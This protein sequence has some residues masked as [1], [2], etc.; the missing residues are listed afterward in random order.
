MKW[1][2]LAASKLA[3]RFGKIIVIE[4]LESQGYTVSK[5]RKTHLPDPDPDLRD[6]DIGNRGN[7]L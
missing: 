6:G 4:Y 5:I 7:K 2:Y 3:D 1:L